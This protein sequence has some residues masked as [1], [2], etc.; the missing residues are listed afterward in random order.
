ML[1]IGVNNLA[2][3]GLVAAVWWVYVDTW[4]PMIKNRQLHRRG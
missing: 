4:S 2:F 3:G 1:K